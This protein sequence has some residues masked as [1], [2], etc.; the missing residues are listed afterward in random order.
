VAILKVPP[1]YNDQFSAARMSTA[2]SPKFDLHPPLMEFG[3]QSASTRKLNTQPSLPMLASQPSQDTV[4]WE[5]PSM[6]PEGNF[7]DDLQVM[8]PRAQEPRPSPLQKLLSV[9]CCCRR[10]AT[11]KC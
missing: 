11:L 4:Q 3:K 5:P 9:V 6:T 8:T 7:G 10:R 1:Q 2:N